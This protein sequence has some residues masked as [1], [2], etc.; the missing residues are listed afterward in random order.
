MVWSCLSKCFEVGR[1]RCQSQ[2]HM[3][4]MWPRNLEMV[5]EKRKSAVSVHRGDFLKMTSSCRCPRLLRAGAWVVRILRAKKRPGCSAVSLQACM[6]KRMSKYHGYLP[7]IS[8]ERDRRESSVAEKTNDLVT[9]IQ[10]L[11]RTWKKISL[12][13]CSAA[14]ERLLRYH[15]MER[16]RWKREN[17]QNTSQ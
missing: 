8:Y 10:Q 14:K 3:C 4:L 2:R 1:H 9:T 12:Q 13:F 15:T 6:R 7:G 5:H 17:M 11:F 16:V